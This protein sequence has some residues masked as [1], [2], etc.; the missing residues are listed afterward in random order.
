[1]RVPR[2]RTYAELGEVLKCLD[3]VERHDADPYMTTRFRGIWKELQ[4]LA[5][6]LEDAPLNE[7]H[8]GWLRDLCHLMG[9]VEF[10][11]A[12]PEESFSSE[13]VPRKRIK[14]MVHS[15]MSRAASLFA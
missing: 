3:G 7:T 11:D 5:V 4:T 6:A 1:M 2:P 14:E 9:V 15:V 13:A 10:I 12:P 8:I